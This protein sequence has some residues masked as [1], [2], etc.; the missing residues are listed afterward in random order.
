MYGL[1]ALAAGPAKAKGEQVLSV[2]L[3]ARPVSLGKGSRWP[4]P[5]LWA[6]GVLGVGN[7][8]G[9]AAVPLEGGS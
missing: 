2:D 3:E 1:G 4:W 8:R 9:G 6:Q 5:S 7:R